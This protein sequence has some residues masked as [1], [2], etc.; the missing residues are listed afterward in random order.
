MPLHRRALPQLSEDLFLTD[1]G[2]ETDLIFNDGV[3]LP[4]FAAFTLLNT[5][6]GTAMLRRYFERYVAIAVRHRRGFILESPTWRANRDWGEKL[7]YDDASL[8]RANRDA[9]ELMTMLRDGSGADKPVVISG[10]IG[11]RGDGYDPGALMSIDEAQEYHGFQADIF[12]GTKADMI[13]AI[14]MTNAAEAIGL[15][16]AAAAARMPVAISFTV[17][18]DGRL[19]TGQ[20][21]GDAIMEVD[22]ESRVAPAYYM[23]NCAHPTHFAHVLGADEPWLG[24]IKGLRVNASKCSHA[25]LNEAPSLDIGDPLELGRENAALRRLLP[26]LTVLGGCCGTDA[27]HIE[28]I[29]RAA[30]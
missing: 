11:P 29:A 14:T 2:I 16:R 24:R 7:G 15:S 5:P 10:C 8:A 27:R 12:A 18:T 21:L 4:L 19:P 6:T 26:G 17:E 23:I 22:F 25:E 3:E 1:G 9:I 13:T 30:A 20:P 28:E